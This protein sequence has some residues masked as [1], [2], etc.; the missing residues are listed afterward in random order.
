MKSRSRREGVRFV[1]VSLAVLL[2][3]IGLVSAQAADARKPQSTRISTLVTG[4]VVEVMIKPGELVEA[5]QLLVRINDADYELDLDE[6]RA[7]V[8][9]AKAELV[10]LEA[11]MDLARASYKIAEERF[12]NGADTEGAVRRAQFEMRSTEAGML[13]GRASLEAAKISEERANLMRS[14]CEIVA[15]REGRVKALRFGVGEFAKRG[16]VVVELETEKD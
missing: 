9:M 13:R 10:A 2:A 16:Q 4:E 15:P 14:R 11:A 8:E 12:K 6:A 5:G 1:S 7:T 3:S